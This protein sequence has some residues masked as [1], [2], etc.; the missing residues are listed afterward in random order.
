[1]SRTLQTLVAA[2]VIAFTSNCHAGLVVTYTGPAEYAAAFTTAE[3]TWESLLTGYQDGFI[4]NRSSG[5]SYNI[6]DTL[7]DL[8]ITANVVA[9]DGAGGILG[10]AGP[11]QS[12]LDSSGFQLSTD[13]I[14]QFDSADVAGLFNSGTWE[15]VILHEMGHV[16]GFGTQWLSNGVYVSDSGEFTGANAT[17]AWQTEFGQTGTPDVELGGGPGTRNGHWN[18]VD[19][20]AGL[21]GITDALGRDMRNELMTGWLNNGSFISNMTV[22]SFKDIGFTIAAVPEPSSLALVA[23]GASCLLRRRRSML[24]A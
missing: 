20:G 22:Q 3:A 1:M 14:M 12:V 9:I 24:A 19:N 7:T 21:T 16:L 10:Q 6:G 4:V 17:L 15:A 13:G 5:S 2:I 18:E 11:T 23:I 8:F